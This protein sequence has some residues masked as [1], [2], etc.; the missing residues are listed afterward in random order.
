M[1]LSLNDFKDY[2]KSSNDIHINFCKPIWDLGD[3]GSNDRHVINH[4]IACAMGFTG[5]INLLT[6]INSGLTYDLIESL[7]ELIP[8]EDLLLFSDEEIF[9]FEKVG[10]AAIRH[11]SNKYTG[12]HYKVL[13][14]GVVLRHPIA[15]KPAIYLYN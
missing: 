4:T 11:N 8:L 9:E 1:I 13:A 2:S 6:E 12:M 14:F 10:V 15:G 5:R 7:N 3:I